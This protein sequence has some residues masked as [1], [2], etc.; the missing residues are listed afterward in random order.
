MLL[1]SVAKFDPR[2]TD[3]RPEKTVEVLLYLAKR[4]SKFDQYKACKMLFLSDKRHLVR[5]ARTIT[6]DA[7]DALE[8]GP[9]PSLTRDRI[10]G[11]LRN[12]KEDEDLGKAFSL[13]EQ[14]KYP[15]LVARRDADLGSLSQSNIQVLDETIEEYGNKG[16]DELKALTHEMTAY[17]NA[18]K[19]SEKKPNA[20]PM[21]FEDFFEQDEDAV[22]GALEEMIENLQLRRR[23]GT[24]C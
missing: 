16:F 9:I 21:S 7:Y 24:A 18:W 5:F 19:P 17:K 11:L 2:F 20:F 3:Y 14:Y 13:D 8:H 15:R 10:K 4:V 12:P 1:Y 22:K 23:F 6:G